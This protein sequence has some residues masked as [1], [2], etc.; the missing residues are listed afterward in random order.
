[1]IAALPHSHDTNGDQILIVARNQFIFEIL[2]Q[3]VVYVMLCSFKQFAPMNLSK[4]RW[5]V[6]LMIRLPQAGLS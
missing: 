1:M 6:G 5:K 2:F 4:T 3:E